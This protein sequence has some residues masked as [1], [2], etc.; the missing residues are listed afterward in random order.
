MVFSIFPHIA[1]R[2]Q[3]KISGEIV[4]KE[5]F[6]KYKLYVQG[7]LQSG[8]IVKGIWK[9][10]LQRLTSHA[11][12]PDWQVSRLTNVL[13]LGLGGGTV[14]KLIDKVYL[15][16]HF[17]KIVGIEIDPEIIKISRK[18]FGLDK[19]KNL[20]IIQADAFEW[21]ARKTPRRWADALLRGGGKKERSNLI[22]ID[23]Y[24]GKK[25][26]KKAESEEFLENIKKRLSKDGVAIFNRLR[27]READL[28]EFE[29]KLK[30]HF[31]SVEKV[32][33]PTNLF[34]IVWKLS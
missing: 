15:K 26:P 11:R 3:S 32:K 4:V 12:P 6:G 1:C 34:F 18:Y 28:T 33:T 19:I 25:Y 21:V 5:Q 14:V 10:L 7:T 2:S 22:I 17:V 30:R 20:K 29:K 9:K 16:E 8:G 27:V 13:I 24:L 31:F 23:L